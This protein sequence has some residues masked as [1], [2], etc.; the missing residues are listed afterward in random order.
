MAYWPT[1]HSLRD[2]LLIYSKEVAVDKVA[3]IS[4][5]L[6]EDRLQEI[7]WGVAPSQSRKAVS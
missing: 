6:G 7:I 3:L 1:N 4:E 5:T 2:D